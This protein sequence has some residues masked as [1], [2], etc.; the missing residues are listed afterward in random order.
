[1]QDLAGQNSYFYVFDKFLGNFACVS[2]FFASF[3]LE[4]F[5]FD[6]LTLIQKNS[7]KTITPCCFLT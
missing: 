7:S 1:M 2:S 6:Y 3:A 4:K 5:I